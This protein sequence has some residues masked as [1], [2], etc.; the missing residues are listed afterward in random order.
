MLGPILVCQVDFPFLGED[1]EFE[2]CPRSLNT[3]MIHLASRCILF[4]PEK[5]QFFIAWRD[6]IQ[7][8]RDA[9]QNHPGFM[10]SW[11]D[12]LCRSND[13]KCS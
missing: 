10:E 8:R 7:V 9:K 5:D 1:S 6:N 3:R 2:G 4:R 12:S 13:L 11:R